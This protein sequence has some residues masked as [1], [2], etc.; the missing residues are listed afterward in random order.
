VEDRQ[1]LERCPLPL[2]R[3]YLRY[4]NASS[5]RERHDHAYFLFEIYLKY[6]AS[7]AI[8]CY[9]AGGTPDHRV[10]AALKGLVRPSL[11]EWIR[12]LRECADFLT[13]RENPAGCIAAVAGLLR[14]KRAGWPE[15][16]DLYNA[17]R[18]FLGRAP[19][20]REKVSLEMLL[21]EV[22]AYRN[23]A[24]G[25]GAPLSSEHYEHFGDLFAR[26]F[27]DVV[28]CSPFLTALRL[29]GFTEIEIRERSQVECGLMEYMGVQPVR[30]REPHRIPYGETVPD[31][32]RLYLLDPEGVLL[33]LDPLLV[34]H[35]EDVY[36]LN[37]ARGVPE[38]LSYSTGERCRRSQLGGREEDLFERILGRRVDEGEL[39]RIAED[40]DREIEEVPESAATGAE[41][42]IGDY[43]IVREVGRG[44]MGIVFEAI[45]T[46]LGRRVALKVLPGTFA[47]DPRRVE[48]FRREARAAA[49]VHHPNIVPVYEV[50]EAGGTHYYAMEYIHGPSLEQLIAQTR[51]QRPSD[52]RPSGPA[53]SDPTYIAHA[54]EQVAGLA[55]GLQEAHRLGLIHRDVKP[56][57]ILVAP[58]GRYVLVDFGLVR[59][60]EAQTITRSGEMVGTLPY[61]SP[62][63]VSRR[64]IDP[65]ADVYSLGA[66]LYE[67]LTLRPPFA[68]ESDHAIQNAILFDEP[69]RP[70]R[71]NSRL[72]RDVETIVLHAIE[73]KPERRY[74]SMA[75]FAGDLR[76]LLRYEP[77]RARAVGPALRA[78]RW[79]QRN[80]AITTGIV[81]AFLLLSVSL[82]ISLHFLHRVSQAL[83]RAR[84]LG[85][86]NAAAQAVDTD[87]MLS[88][89]LAR[90][91][92]A[93]DRR[94]ETLSQVYE[95]LAALRERAILSGHEGPVNSASYSPDGARIL[96]A[97]DDGTARLWTREGKEMAVLRGHGAR[98]SIAR[99]SPRQDLILTASND[100]TARLW[101]LE[102]REVAVLR[103][104]E[105]PITGAV[106]SPSDDLVLTGS[107]D[108]SARLW[109][110]GGNE[111]RRLLGHTGWISAVAFS[112]RGDRI[113]TTA[114]YLVH[115]GPSADFTAR[116]WSVSSGETIAVLKGHEDSIL[117]AA[118]SPG[119]DRILTVSADRT[120]RIWE[121]EGKEVAVCRGHDDKPQP[122]ACFSHDGRF[123]LTGSA[124]TTA[125]MWDGAGALVQVFRGHRG[126][127]YSALFS[128]EGDRILTA[129]A[130]QTARLFDRSG[131]ELAVLAGHDSR[132]YSAVFSPDG[133]EIL[134]ASMD[135]TARLWDVVGREMPAFYGHA[136]GL[137]A[138]AFSPRG[139]RIAT[140][141]GDRTVRL[142]DL[143]G[144]QRAIMEGHRDWVWVVAFSPDGSR[145]LSGSE[146]HTARLWDLDGKG[147]AVFAGHE[148]PIASVH[149]HPREERILTSSD[150]GTVR[151]WEFQGKERARFS[152]G[153]D[154]LTTAVFSPDGEEILTASNDRTARRWDLEGKEIAIFRGHTEV[155]SSAAFSPSADRIL[156]A[157]YDGTVR[158]WDRDGKEV[159]VFRGHEG[160]VLGALFSPDGRRILTCSRDNTARLWDLDGRELAALRGHK[161]IV[162]TAVFSPS[163]DRILTASWDKT[164]RLWP[165]EPDALLR[166]AERRISRG[167]TEAERH[168]F[169]DLL[170]P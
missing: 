132:V 96:T 157:S 53:S 130:D 80:P 97:S 17:L 3:L 49:R 86:A 22:V 9:L 116:L 8:A 81:G 102:G 26:A 114:G 39:E 107:Q 28:E 52:G 164:A 153:G 128:S 127:V 154:A 37:E 25:H 35:E 136:S 118:F 115:P 138:A 85:L 112:P 134:T 59:E 95:A 150:D 27:R 6:V 76:R 121:A 56:S 167:F 84:A 45:Q 71:L 46:S 108:G 141:S 72:N 129:S 79:A 77:I 57:N 139:D 145:I 63:Q 101:D 87:P 13:G 75:E 34:A 90:E 60:E 2:A 61:M 158:L 21:E 163:G 149:F 137:F 33:C 67:I 103:G 69:I 43:R 54:V 20:A 92:V 160:V 58:G 70:R 62:E 148:G 82:A 41:Q 162:F 30:R 29:V 144:K 117:A 100:K 78:K 143:E 113:L 19:S 146:D 161:A 18:S 156:T 91:A 23:R 74:G 32:N 99:F 159:A 64:R 133:G 4:L 126:G 166:L 123:A 7:I 47:L 1:I 40:V 147:L 89:L 151:V 142:W 168:R 11:G 50:G 38:Y 44:A 106:F 31:R 135:H 124:D 16:V 110:L 73:K 140:A 155:V 98:V 42:R 165:A 10:N 111:A 14:E 125:R 5:S 36:I 83:L 119:G 24:L 170:S 68:A 88:L 120:A 66:V 104:H 169:Q 48:R 152:A 105:G 109:D 131:T 12:F 93:L 94:S 15:V 122:S 65:R 55:E 51:A